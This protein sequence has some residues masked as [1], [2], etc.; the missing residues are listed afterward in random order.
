MAI[1]DYANR[2]YDYLALRGVK[3]RDSVRLGLELF[4]SEDSGQIAV[5]VQKLAQRWLLEFL[6]DTGSM[7]GLPTRGTSFMQNIRAG[8]ARN[9]S[10][11]QILFD[12][13]SFAASSNLR[14]EEDDSWPADERFDSVALLN[15]GFTPGYVNLRVLIT[16]VAGASRSI[17]LPISILPQNIG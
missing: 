1:S 3:P 9:S 11:L 7:I 14:D 5:G 2:K 12:L 6:T 8:R 13:A 4:N 16:S 10:D 17:I 15:I